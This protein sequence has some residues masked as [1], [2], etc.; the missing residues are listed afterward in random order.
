[1]FCQCPIEDLRVQMVEAR[2]MKQSE[3]SSHPSPV[4][5]HT[6]LQSVHRIIYSFF[7]LFRGLPAMLIKQIPYTMGKE[8]QVTNQWIE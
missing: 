2:A 4:A 7:Y 8:L 5:S 3:P 6:A 1:M